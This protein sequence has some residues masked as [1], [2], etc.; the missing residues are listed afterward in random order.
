MHILKEGLAGNRPCVAQIMSWA[1]YRTT[2]RVEDRAYSLM[3]LVDVSMPMLY[4]EGGKRFTAF[5]WKSFAHPTTKTS[6]RGV[7]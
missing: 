3:G 6:L 7:T 5:N 4:G 2:S 1:A